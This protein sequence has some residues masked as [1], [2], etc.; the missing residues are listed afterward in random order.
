MSTVRGAASW[1]L[2]KTGSAATDVA[3][4]SKTSETTSESSSVCSHTEPFTAT[5][6]RWTA[7]ATFFVEDR[8]D[9]R[10]FYIV[11]GIAAAVAGVAV[12]GGIAFGLFKLLSSPAVVVSDASAA[13]AAVAV[14]SNESAAAVPVTTAPAAVSSSPISSAPLPPKAPIV[15]VARPIATRLVLGDHYAAPTVR[16]ESS[17]HRAVVFDSDEDPWWASSAAPP[18]VGVP[19]TFYAH[20]DA[21]VHIE[22]EE[23]FFTEYR[24][25]NPIVPS[26]DAFGPN[27][28]LWYDE[29]SGHVVEL[30]PEGQTG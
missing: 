13:G 29:H 22:D 30:S 12:L 15:G 25:A 14:V 19:P 10:P 28:P 11:V 4:A 27:E 2:S 20:R 17:T 8:T 21:I 9:T 24:D 7:T 3:T 18:P 16:Q 6:T 5:V 1:S 23:P 26:P